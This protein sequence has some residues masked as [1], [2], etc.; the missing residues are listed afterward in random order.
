MTA[1]N[2]LPPETASAPARLSVP[3]LRPAEAA[4]LLSVRPSWIYEAVRTNRLPC[5]RVGRHIRFT[6]EMLEAW[7]AEQSVSM[8]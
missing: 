1:L 7:L 5:L 3:P 8:T 6:R 2:D 4:E